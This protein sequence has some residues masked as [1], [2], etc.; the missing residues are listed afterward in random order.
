MISYP[1]WWFRTRRPGF[2][3]SSPWNTLRAIEF[4]RNSLGLPCVSQ[5]R[6][7][8]SIRVKPSVCNSLR[9][10][11]RPKPCTNLSRRSLL[12]RINNREVNYK[13]VKR[14]LSAGHPRMEGQRLRKDQ[15]GIPSL[16]FRTHQ[17]SVIAVNWVVEEFAGLSRSELTHRQRRAGNHTSGCRWLAGGRQVLRESWVLLPALRPGVC[18]AHTRRDAGGSHQSYAGAARL[19]RDCVHLGHTTA[20]CHHTHPGDCG[21]G[22]EKA[23]P[24]PPDQEEKLLS[25]CNVLPATPIDRAPCGGLGAEEVFKGSSPILQNRY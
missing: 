12:E 9:P 16:A 10:T 4:D 2:Q 24:I 11:R 1:L 7:K 15:C 22:A 20:G 6:Q 19:L 5:T 25:S 17:R 3:F 18:D 14:T 13:A 8:C 23:K 21:A